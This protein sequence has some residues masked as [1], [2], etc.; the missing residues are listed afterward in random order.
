MAE[1][2]RRD[3]GEQIG[4]A[5]SLSAAHF[6]PLFLA[7][8][9][10]T[11][12]VDVAWA[13]LVPA[14]IYSMTFFADIDQLM[15][16]VERFLQGLAVAGSLSLITFPLQTAACTSLA[17]APFLG[18]RPRLGPAIRDGFRVFFPMLF[19]QLGLTIIYF[20]GAFAFLLPLL[21]FIAWFYVAAPVVVF[22]KV[23]WIEALQRSRKLA[24]GHYGETLAMFV[25]MLL[26]SGLGASFLV[27]PAHFLLGEEQFYAQYAIQVLCTSIMAL[28]VTVAPVV[29]Y[30]HLRVV[31]EAYDVQRLAEFVDVVAER[32]A[33]PQGG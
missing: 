32:G 29:S 4:E 17:G 1:L 12:P 14:E 13:L 5:F 3:L 23:G 2:R 16:V 11:L 21:L 19:L 28:P 7:T 27:L 15:K 18:A 25:V 22:E 26:V 10:F 24:S 20:F 33:Q 30:F 31:K 9:L 8:L 6:G